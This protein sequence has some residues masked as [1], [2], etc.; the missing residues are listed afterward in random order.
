MPPNFLRA[1][2][3]TQY[4]VARK[5]GFVGTKEEYEN[6]LID[7]YWIPSVTAE[8]DGSAI[9]LN[10]TDWTIQTGQGKPPRGYLLL[11]GEGVVPDGGSGGD[12]AGG[13]DF[14]GGGD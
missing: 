1:P 2:G 11:N 3:L 14:G 13:G 12:A 7:H 4:E 10:I 5:Q 9:Y 8:V 6:S